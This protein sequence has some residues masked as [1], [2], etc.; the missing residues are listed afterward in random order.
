MDYDID[1]SEHKVVNGECNQCWITT[2]LKCDCGGIVHTQFGD[3]TQDG[4]WLLHK[5]EKCG[6]KMPGKNGKDSMNTDIELYPKAQKLYD[7]ILVETGNLISDKDVFHKLVILQHWLIDIVME[8]GKKWLGRNSTLATITASGT[9][10][11]KELFF[12]T[13]YGSVTVKDDELGRKLL[14]EYFD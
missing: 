12:I 13:K 9:G 6:S 8:L 5:C 11:K 3:D 2:P 4:Y 10:D 7:I 1:L 14:P